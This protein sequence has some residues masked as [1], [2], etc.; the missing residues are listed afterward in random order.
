M[1]E[2]KIEIV[3]AEVSRVLLMS[4]PFGGMDIIIL[5]KDNTAL[6]FKSTP[7]ALA[8]LSR[9]GLDIINVEDLKK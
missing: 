5:Y 1:P 7:Q 8:D 6:T 9:T 3:E 4:D 2:I